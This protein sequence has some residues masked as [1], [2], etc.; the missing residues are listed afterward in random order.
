[1]SFLAKKMAIDMGTS[2]TRIYVPRKGIVINEPSVVAKSRDSEQIVAVGYAAVDMVGRTPDSYE[3][4]YPL[5]HG[6]IADYRATERMLKE[7]ISRAVGRLH[8]TKPEAM[9]SVSTAATS[10]EQRAVIDVGKSAGLSDVFLIKSATAAA[11]GAGIPIIEPRGSLII[12]IGGGTTEIAV[13]SLGGVVAEHAIRSGGNSINDSVV[14]YVRR[15]HGLTIGAG[16]GEEIKQ[17]IGSVAADAKNN[18]ITARGLSVADGLPQS[19][20]LSSKDIRGYLE[21]SFEKIILAVRN[22]LEKTP[23][24]IISDIVEDGIYLSG[25]TSQLAGIDE[26]LTRKLKVNCHVAQDPALCSAKGAHLALSHVAEYK[27]SLL[28]V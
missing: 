21:A 11:L 14:R 9:M 4:F 13:H 27:K 22:V 3:A 25:G 10:T 1:M 5:K 28:G 8:I 20:T 15:N 19:L 6:V 26:Y 2:F 17:L 18:T 12:D 23:P 16:V 24:D 7:F